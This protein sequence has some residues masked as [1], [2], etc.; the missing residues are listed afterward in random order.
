MAIM[1]GSV[2]WH[3]NGFD[4]MSIHERLHSGRFDIHCAGDF[5]CVAYDL[6]EKARRKA[7]E[8]LRTTSKKRPTAYFYYCDIRI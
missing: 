7:F 6:P 8:A 2:T 3:P 5:H 1:R 4:S